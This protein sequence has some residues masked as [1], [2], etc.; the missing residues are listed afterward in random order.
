LIKDKLNIA[1]ETQRLIVMGKQLNDNK[2]L[3][4]YSKS[5]IYKKKLIYCLR[6]DIFQNF[7]NYNLYLQLN[8]ILK[9]LFYSIMNIQF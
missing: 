7:F 2:K 6:I 5:Y 3:S 8:K 1:A 4:E 9:I